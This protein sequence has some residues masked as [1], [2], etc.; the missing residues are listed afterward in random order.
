MALDSEKPLNVVMNREMT[1]YIQQNAPEQYRE[2]RDFVVQNFKEYY[3]TSTDVLIDQHIDAYE[4]QGISI[5]KEEAMDELVANAS[6]MF[7]TDETTGKKLAKENSSLAEK[8]LDYIK[9]LVKRIKV[10]M[11][12]VKPHSQEARMRNE[13]LETAQQAEKLWMEALHEA[14][15]TEEEKTGEISIKNIRLMRNSIRSMMHGTKRTGV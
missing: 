14:G 3:G 7:L 9:G 13:N 1:H 8:I 5:T 6:E 11:K 15:K 12:D 10:M 2:Y 4:R